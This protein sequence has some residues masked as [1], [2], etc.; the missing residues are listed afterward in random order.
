MAPLNYHMPTDIRTIT[1]HT[2]ET[3]GPQ[4]AAKDTYSMCLN[5]VP[6]NALMDGNTEKLVK[7]SENGDLFSIIY[8]QKNKIMELKSQNCSA[9]LP[10]SIMKQLNF[11]VQTIEKK[12]SSK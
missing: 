12:R 9:D 1:Y 2:Q 5:T 3:F 4:I 6:N 11:L 7:C 8:K 10:M